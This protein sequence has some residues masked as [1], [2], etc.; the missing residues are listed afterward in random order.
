[1]PGALINTQED[2]SG[3][4]AVKVKHAGKTYF[5]AP[6]LVR[7]QYTPEYCESGRTQTVLAVLS[8]IFLLIQSGEFL[9]APENTLIQR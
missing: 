6:Q 1:V 2:G 9:K 5:A 4:Y 7:N 8:Q 3:R